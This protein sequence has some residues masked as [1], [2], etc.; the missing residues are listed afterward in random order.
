MDLLE[1]PQKGLV[2][3]CEIL[4]IRLGFSAH[5]SLMRMARC[6]YLLCLGLGALGLSGCSSSITAPP[7]SLRIIPEGVFAKDA[8]LP[9]AHSIRPAPGIAP[10]RRPASATPSKVPAILPDVSVWLYASLASQ[11]QLMQFGADP[12]SGVRTWENY[13]GANKIPFSRITTAIDMGRIPNVGVLI[14]PS[15]VALSEDERQ[16]VIQWRNRGGS[17]LSTWLTATHS[18]TGKFTGYEFMRDV[19]DVQVVGNTEKEVDDTFMMVHGDSVVAHSLPAGTRVWLER[20]PQQ[21]PLR[22]IAKQSAAQIMS[23]SRGYDT[24][25]PSGLLTF[26]EREMPSGKFSRTATMGYPEQNWVRSDPKQLNALTGD[27]LSWLQRQPQVY[28]G[29]WPYP[30]QGALL[31]AVQAAET[32]ADVDVAFAKALKDVGGRATYYVHGGNVA[33]AAEAIKKVQAL[34]HEIGYLG[35]LFEGFKDQPESTQAERLDAMQQQIASASITIPTP[36]SFSP[37]LD[38][39][40]KTT[41]RVLAE[42]KFD[43]YVAFMELTD[44]CLPFFANRSED[45]SGQMAVLSRTQ[46]APEESL[47]ADDPAAGFNSFLEGLDISVSMGCLSIVR[48]PAQSLLT[49]EQRKQLL[50]KIQTLRKRAWTVSAK[51]ITQWWRNRERVSVALHP[52]PKGY[53]LTVSVKHPVTSKEPLSILVNLPQRNSRVRLQALGKVKKVPA[54]IEIDPW[55]VAVILHEPPIGQQEWLLQFE[56]PLLTKKR[57]EAE[58]KNGQK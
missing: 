53:L 28:L 43:N 7:E 24:N 49:P 30:Y 58:F 15:A 29:A 52:H 39:Y 10:K 54:V 4:A 22:L 6:A 32:V 21:L 23:W 44:T 41:Q 47:D 3:D 31:V 25:K 33:K 38:S 20:V 42:H 37:P 5:S 40:D 55:R 2:D 13:L 45:G 27:I 48:L 12:T 46:I 9:I 11:S 36:A 16:A 26:D 56:E 19:L 35:D 8:P 17:I 18:E 50:D 57:Q 34:G 14:L 51:Q 1:S